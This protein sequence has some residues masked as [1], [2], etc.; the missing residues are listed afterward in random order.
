MAHIFCAHVVDLF[1]KHRVNM[2]ANI[3]FFVRSGK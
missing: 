1:H 2:F 3:L